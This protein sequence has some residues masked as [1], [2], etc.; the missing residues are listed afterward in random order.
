MAIS[1][2][3]AGDSRVAE[4]DYEINVVIEI[5]QEGSIKYEIDKDSG[6]LVVDRFINAAMQYP[7]N[8]GYIPNTLAQD[9]DP[10]DVF[11]ISQQPL[12]PGC[13]IKVRPIAVLMMEDESGIDEKIIAV[14]G[15]KIDPLYSNYKDLEDIPEITKQKIKH[16]LEHYK[17]LEKGK[18]VKVQD[19]QNAAKA[20][21]LVVKYEDQYKSQK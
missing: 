13:Q 18:W 5:A 11:V 3:I 12:I 20:K 2:E 1:T 4:K 15:H 14:P 9:G 19:W 8:Y 7:A 16:F 21:E 17:D 6:R 10:L